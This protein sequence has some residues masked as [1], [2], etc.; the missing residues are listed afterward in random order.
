MRSEPGHPAFQ[1]VGSPEK[2]LRDEALVS[3][4]RR[5]QWMNPDPYGPITGSPEEVAR[6]VA[7]LKSYKDSL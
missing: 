4:F 1:F 6:K 7:L 3:E 2:I 5:R